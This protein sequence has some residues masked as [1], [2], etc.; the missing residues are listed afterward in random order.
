[1]HLLLLRCFLWL[2]VGSLIQVLYSKMV[3]INN[4]ISLLSIDHAIFI[5]SP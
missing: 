3:P 1:M 2:Q 5:A 4:Q